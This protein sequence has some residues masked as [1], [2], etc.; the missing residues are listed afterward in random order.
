MG[1][2]AFHIFFFPERGRSQLLF[3]IL[4]WAF[5]THLFWTKQEKELRALPF[6]FPTEDWHLRP[7]WLNILKIF[8]RAPSPPHPTMGSVSWKT[9]IEI[10]I[11]SGFPFSHPL[12]LSYPLHPKRK[13]PT[14]TP[15]H[16]V[17]VVCTLCRTIS[18]TG[19]LFHLPFCINAPKNPN[20]QQIP[21]FSPMRKLLCI[22]KT[23]AFK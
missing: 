13:P 21:A 1:G 8:K 18:K 22:F 11:N 19:F 23:K 17:A 5:L 9:E 15:L 12:F 20:K 16:L 10:I 14:P 3:F 4:I 6:L 2:K 7:I